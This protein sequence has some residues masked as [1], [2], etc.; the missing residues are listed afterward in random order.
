[1]KC[2]RQ[3]WVVAENPGN[4]RLQPLVVVGDHQ[5]DAAQPA[6]G[7]AAQEGG[8]EGLGLRRADRHAE[9][10]A[11]S[12]V[13]DRDRHG[14][15]DRDDAPGLAHL[16]IGRIQPEIGPLALQRPLEEALDL[17]VDLAAQPRHLALGDARHPH[18]LHQVVHRAGRHALDVSLLDHR[19][20]R[21]LGHPP[22]LQEAG[23]VA[24]FPQLRDFQLDRAGAGLPDPV[25]VAVA[26]VDPL[27]RAL[28]VSRAGQPLHLERHQPLG[29]KADHLAKQI[30]V[31]T[32]LQ[33]PP[34]G[35]H[36]IGHRGSSSGSGSL[37]A[38]N[39]KPEPRWPPLW[40]SSPPP[41]DSRRSLRRA[42]YPQLPEA[43][44]TPTPRPGTRPTVKRIVPA[45]PLARSAR[46]GGRTQYPPQNAGRRSRSGSAVG[47]T[48]SEGA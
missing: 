13:V 8:P 17:A 28:A 21:L 34:Q 44:R 19:G 39:P 30:G 47:R 33:K 1:M 37:Q 43:A 5:L 24:P 42:A 3:R 27:R 22:W 6:A 12:L 23:E 48:G 26:V 31:G 14:H 16:Q 7:E 15:R 11:P 41:P 45:R 18:R 20:Q 32:L 38:P 10:L 40:I 35:H 29:R 25:P 46:A 36:V 9:D 4:G 2:T